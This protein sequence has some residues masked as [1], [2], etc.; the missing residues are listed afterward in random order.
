[1]G[2]GEV[3]VSVYPDFIHVYARRESDEQTQCLLPE[4]DADLRL[5]Q[6]TL[7]QSRVPFEQR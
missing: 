3:W 5:G 7:T 2:P 1:M 6:E 4:C